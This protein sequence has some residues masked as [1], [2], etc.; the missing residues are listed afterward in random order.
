MLNMQKQKYMQLM[1]NIEDLE[2]RIEIMELKEK[3]PAEL[4]ALREKLA[5]A[6]NELARV[7]DGCGTPHHH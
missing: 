4:D 7:S 3:P 2:D 5:E 6:R 1:Q